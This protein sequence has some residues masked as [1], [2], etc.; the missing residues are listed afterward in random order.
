M[1]ATTKLGNGCQ[2]TEENA[3]KI[4]IEAKFQSSVPSELEIGEGVPP[5]GLDFTEKS[6]MPLPKIEPRFFGRP[7]RS[8]STYYSIFAPFMRSSPIGSLDAKFKLTVSPSHTEN[9]HQ[10]VF[11]CFK[12][13][14]VLTLCTAA[15]LG[16]PLY[17]HNHG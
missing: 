4:L 16:G 17:Y 9:F 5:A 3:D 11:K 8:L 7:S 13:R 2:E 15:L 6:L 12:P 10:C 1:L 14:S